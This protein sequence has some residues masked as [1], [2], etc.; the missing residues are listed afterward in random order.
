MTEKTPFPVVQV[1]NRDGGVNFDVGNKRNERRQLP[2]IC[3]LVMITDLVLGMS[4]K[5]A[6]E[7]TLQCLL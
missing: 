2:E 1:E 5:T 7:R 6:S 3:R 4:E